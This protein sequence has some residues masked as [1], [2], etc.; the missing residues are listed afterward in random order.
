MSRYLTLLLYSSGGVTCLAGP[1]LPSS[2]SPFSSPE[3]HIS[4]NRKYEVPI[5]DFALQ[6]NTDRRRVISRKQGAS[7]GLA[8][9]TPG[10]TPCSEI[11]FARA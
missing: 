4:L 5:V 2:F 11:A 7:R 9:P 1:F 10:G 6:A 8:M 3:R